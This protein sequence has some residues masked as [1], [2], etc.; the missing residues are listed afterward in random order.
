MSTLQGE[1]VKPSWTPGGEPATLAAAA[2]DARVWLLFVQ[3]QHLLDF[4]AWKGGNPETLEP[5]LTAC[6]AALERELRQPPSTGPHCRA[7]GLDLTPTPEQ[8]EALERFG[9]PL[10]R[11]PCLQTASGLHEVDVEAIP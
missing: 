7:C 9:N 4:P 11:P 2:E 5:R 10:R 6:I 3:D 1:A 8:R